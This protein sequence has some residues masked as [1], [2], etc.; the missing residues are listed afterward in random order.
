MNK[1]TAKEKAQWKKVLKSFT[2]F[3]DALVE[4]GNNWPQIR[5]EVAEAEKN[6]KPDDFYAGIS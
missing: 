3:K 1:L 4:L 5:K 2:A 6:K